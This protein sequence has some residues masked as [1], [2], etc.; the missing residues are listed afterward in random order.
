MLYLTIISL[1]HRLLLF[2]NHAESTLDSM[3][4]NDSE[5]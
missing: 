3:T 4:D 5:C 1:G 2:R